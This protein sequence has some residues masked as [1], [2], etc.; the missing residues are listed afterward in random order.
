MLDSTIENSSKNIHPM[1]LASFCSPTKRYLQWQ[2]RK[3]RRMTDCIRTS[4]KQEE[5]RRDK[6]PA[7]TTFTHWWH[8]WASKKWLP[9]Y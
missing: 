4:I 3:T 7:H 1:T 5:R 8:Q 2:H 9:L 6:T